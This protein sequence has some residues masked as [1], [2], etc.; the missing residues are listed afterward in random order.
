MKLEAIL[1]DIYINII[2]AR[3]IILSFIFPQGGIFK[4]LLVYHEFTE[5]IDFLNNIVLNVIQNINSFNEKEVES[6]I[7]QLNMLS[8]TNNE[9]MKKN[10]YL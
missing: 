10:N 4:R 6:N 5:C 8:L 3:I 9:K 7:G 1:F 2:L